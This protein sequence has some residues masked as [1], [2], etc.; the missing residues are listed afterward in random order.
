MV[1]GLG[2]VVSVS[3]S[4]P[5]RDLEVE[6]R[7][8]GGVLWSEVALRGRDVFDAVVR[9]EDGPNWVLDLVCRR[10]GDEEVRGGLKW[11][12]GCV[13][14][15]CW[16]WAAG[17]E[18]RALLDAGKR[19]VVVWCLDLRGLRIEAGV[20]TRGGSGGGCVTRGSALDDA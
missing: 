13:R 18:R 11:R 9:A 14:Y 4:D 16:G 1:L 15:T 2:H 8:V 3:A 20:S 12:D 6:L 5:F 19:L 10:E 17:W 7:G